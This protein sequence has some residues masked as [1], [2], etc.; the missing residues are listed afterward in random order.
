MHKHYVIKS[1][2]LIVC[3]F[4]ANQALQSQDLL[5]SSDLSQVRI[6][7][8]SDA[9]VI[10][11][12]NQMASSGVTI[13]Q[14]EQM[15]L[16]KG[17]SAT[18]FAK[19]KQRLA[20]LNVNSNDRSGIGRLKPSPSPTSS[21]QN[22]VLDSL[23]K[24]RYDRQSSLPLINPLIFGS[25]LYTSVAPSFE[26]SSSLATPVNYVLG[27]NDQILV[28]VFGVQQSEDEL[29][30]SPEGVVSIPNVGRIKIAGLTIEEATQKLKTVMGNSV[31]PYLKSGGAQLSVT[32]SS[33]RSIKVTVIGSNLPANYT[34]SSLSTVFNVLYIA[35]GPSEFG[36]FR[37]IELWRNNKLER[38]VDLYRLLLRGD[39]SD[40]VGLKDNDVIR[41]P[42]YKTRVEIQGQVKRPG[43]FEV[44][45]G[46]SFSNIL[47][48]ASGF[49]D[50]AYYSSVKV[51]QRNDRERKIFDLVSS[52]YPSY[53]PQSGDV[54]IVSKI[55]NRFSNRVS[56][57]GAVFRPDVYEL[58]PGLTVS[59]LID[60]ADG[61]TED[62]FTG[63]AQIL[64]LEEDLTRS[65]VSFD[66]KKALTGDPANN[67]ILQREDEVLITSVQELKDTFKVTIQGEVRIPG[68]YDYIHNLTLKDL[69]LQAGGFTN[70]AYKD[71][72]IARLIKRDSIIFTDKK[73]NNIINTEINN[74]LSSLSGSIPL[75]PFDVITIR[76]KAGYTLP[77]S[78]IVTGQ[79]QHPGPYAL[80]T[81][82]ERVSDI[83]KRAGGY[84]PDAFPAGA[85]L[86][87]YVSNIDKEKSDDDL[88]TLQKKVNDSSITN[89]N[90]QEEVTKKYDKIPLDLVR[91]DAN[92]GSV[93]D[94]I[95]KAN[96]ELYIPI[97]ES[98]VKIVG[99][100]LLT[101]QLPYDRGSTYADYVAAAGGFGG[102]A[103]KGK[104]FIVYANG[105]AATTKHFLFFKSYPKVLPGSTLIIPGKPEKKGLSTGEI[106]GVS[107][108]LASLAGV[109]IA[110]LRL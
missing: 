56:I 7:Q 80:S 104:S 26:P 60:R 41:I 69:I 68:Q 100:V 72:E 109:V 96:D 8:L 77:E 97:F 4:F 54:F 9:D 75:Q 30:V 66:I 16:S 83:L 23:D 78:V 59:Q 10:K 63:R 58:T 32:L 74:D 99:S 28:S 71:I 107:S 50:T 91:I 14:A 38:K 62:A 79:V 47:D 92:P 81:R 95:L 5:K 37:E 6:D 65:I 49:T 19:L 48:F 67:I 55:L 25:E 1:V 35:G 21:R 103:W 84:T 102:N 2:I 85:Y 89:S 57:R 108:A 101:T 51:F 12:K 15:A 94:I 17:M 73:V 110:I 29:K 61:V 88:K 87:R 39:Q 22:N 53:Q 52:S 40:N 70:A 18:E 82:D 90:V 64:R 93:E 46:E 27:P 24:P 105:K 44:L 45:P 13:D 76:R 36:S 42:P 98:Q 31:Y 20:A 33:I 34:V 11:L 3:L 86:K 43:I 106:I